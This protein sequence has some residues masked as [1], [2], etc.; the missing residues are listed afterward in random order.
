MKGCPALTALL[1]LVILTGIVCKKNQPPQ[2]P[3]LTTPSSG[4]T[5]DT[6]S[7]TV[8]SSD[9]DGDAVYYRFDWGE[10]DTAVVWKGPHESGLQAE[11]THV[12]IDAGAFSVRVKARDT[13][14]NE[15]EWS[16][17]KSLLVLPGQQLDKPGNLSYEA[18]DSGNALKLE[19]DA[20][21]DA[22]GYRVKVDGVAYETTSTEY[23]V[24]T[25]AKTIEVTA[26]NSTDESDPVVIDCEAVVTVTV[27]V[28]GKSDPSPDHPA[29]FGFTADGAAI[30]YTLSQHANWPLID[31]I[32]DDMVDGMNF[33]SPNGYA[34]PYNDEDNAAV[35]A[36]ESDF[37]AEFL[38]PDM[39]WL[40]E[41]P[42]V[43][44]KV[45]YFW[46]D[47]N[48]NLWDLEDRFA[49]AK[50]VSIVDKKVTLKLAFQTIPG[51]GWLKTD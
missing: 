34:V 12:Y 44:G 46:I 26:Y 28:Y 25:P 21:A 5:G 32:M 42:C 17:P 9:P 19:W 35:E 23:T 10:G 24:D 33:K 48:A 16:D 3:T 43:E 13:N 11:I 4:Y 18:T 6:L 7:F 1:C 20:V 30:T 49:K 51:L 45:Y 22:V 37:D 41:H 8:L 38:A 31:Y 36:I 15:S 29:A 27:E 14:D 40:T 2:T 39:G 50:V 47:P